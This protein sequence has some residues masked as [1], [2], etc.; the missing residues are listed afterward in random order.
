[1]PFDVSIPE[2]LV[3]VVVVL[4]LFGPKR[5][6]EMGRSL[7]KNIREFRDSISG[8]T[9]ATS[10]ASPTQSLPR[11]TVDYSGGGSASPNSQTPSAPVQERETIF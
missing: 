8:L 9:R 7:A 10:A 5:A 4:L 2:M 3:L 1:V 6:P 11:E